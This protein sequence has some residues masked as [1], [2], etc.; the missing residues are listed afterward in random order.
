MHRKKSEF[1]AEPGRGG[2]GMLTHA[3]WRTKEPV[4]NLPFAAHVFLCGAGQRLDFWSVHGVGV[5]L[6]EEL[7]AG[8]EQGVIFEFGVGGEELLGGG[9]RLVQER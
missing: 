5:E 6:E 7:D 8:F 1:C 4:Q 2:A 3:R 9:L